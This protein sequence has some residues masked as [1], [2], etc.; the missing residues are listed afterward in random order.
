MLPYLSLG[1]LL[2]TTAG[3]SPGP[4]MTLVISQS[5]RF[6]VREGLKISLAPLLS[7]L[8]ILLVSWALLSRV[9]G[10]DRLLGL[11]SIAGAIFLLLIA[12][13]SWRAEPSTGPS[14][15]SSA[16]QSDA[17]L[18]RSLS[19]GILANMLNPHPWLFWLTVGAPT[20]V[21][22]GGWLNAVAFVTG[23]YLCLVGAKLIVAAV[24]GHYRQRLN[25]NHH[26]LIL[27]GLALILA[28]IAL[29]MIIDWGGR[30]FA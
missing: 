2:G 3:I 24:V 15:G 14:T 4:M 5:L 12:V 30:T 27:R 22:A 23:F 29:R 16:V 10:F 18:P 7:D 20:L 26:R 1:V 21:T 19:R 8:P 25:P 9:A 13:E 28:V 17:G 11:V 6:G